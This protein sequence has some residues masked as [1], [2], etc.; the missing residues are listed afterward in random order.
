[1]QSKHSNAVGKAQEPAAHIELV[2]RAAKTAKHIASATQC[3]HTK[4]VQHLAKNAINV[5]LR[6]ISVPAPDR[7]GAMA[8]AKTDTEVEHQLEVEAQREVTDPTEADTPGPDNVQ[9][10]DRKLA[11]LTASKLTGMILMTLM[12]SEHFTVFPGQRQ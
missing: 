10:V 2:V 5:V 8:K 4:T 6:I 11:T 7:L 12:Y 1:M 3:T 9:G